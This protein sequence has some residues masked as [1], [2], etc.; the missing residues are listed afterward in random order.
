VTTFERLAR[1]RAPR[2]GLSVLRCRLATGR[3]HQIRVHLAARGW[4]LVGDPQYGQPPG[5]RIDDPDLA[6]V[7]RSFPRQALHAWQVAF[8]HPVTGRLLCLEAP[9]PSDLRQ[10]LDALGL[11]ERDRQRLLSS[12]TTSESATAPCARRVIVATGAGVR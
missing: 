5:S 1:V 8:A 11:A 7:L 3:R 4:P 12:S 10:L 2:A 6:A 9:I